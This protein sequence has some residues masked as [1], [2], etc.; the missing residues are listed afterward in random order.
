MGGVLNSDRSVALSPATDQSARQTAAHS[1]PVARERPTIASALTMPG[2]GMTLLGRL[3][4]DPGDQAAWSDFV[5]GTSPRF[6]SGAE[7][8]CR[9]GNRSI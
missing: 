1:K 8:G 9:A 4:Q 3:R 7:A 6:S 2:P 5:G